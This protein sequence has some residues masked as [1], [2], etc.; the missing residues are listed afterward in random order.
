MFSIL[1]LKRKKAGV[2]FRY[3]FFFLGGGLK[4]LR[5]NFENCKYFF[6]LYLNFDSYHRTFALPRE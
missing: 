1:A 3:K 4:G 2:I 5:A 6:F